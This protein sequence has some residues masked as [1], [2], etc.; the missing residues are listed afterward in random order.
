MKARLAAL[1]VVLLA[2]GCAS[3]PD[4]GNAGDWPDRRQN[5]V[6]V[7][8]WSLDGRVA[9]ASGSEGFSGAL[10][11]HQTGG[12]SEIE[13]RGPLG[14]GTLSIRFDGENYSI[15]DGEGEPVD[16]EEARRR[17]EEFVGAPLPLASLRYWLIGVPA[18][19]QAHVE[20][21]AEGRLQTLEQAGWRVQYTRYMEV[22]AHVLPARLEL[23]AGQFRLRLAV[24]KWQLA[25]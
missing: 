21:L 22:G 12:R 4:A 16:G 1:A 8:V 6:A 9:V 5:L 24:S 7:D 17:T 10:S 20:S 25:P 11:W 15:T 19:D 2:S 18:P 23:T 13:M 3:L 14:A